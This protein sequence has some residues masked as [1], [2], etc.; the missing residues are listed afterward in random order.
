MLTTQLVELGIPVVAAVNMMAIIEKNGDKLNTKNLAKELGYGKNEKGTEWMGQ[1][2]I[3][4]P[5]SY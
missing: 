5:N 4:I 1:L 2:S 3:F